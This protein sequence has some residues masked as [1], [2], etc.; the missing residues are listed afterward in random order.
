MAQLI[1]VNQC[2][3]RYQLDLRAYANRFTWLKKRR[4][5]EWKEKWGNTSTIKDQSDRDDKDNKSIKAQ[6]ENWFFE[7]QVGWATRT[8]F[9]VSQ[10]PKHLQ[11][12]HWVRRILTRINDVSFFMY[13]PVLLTKSGSIQLDSLIIGNDLICCVHPLIG[14]P[15]HVFQ[16]VSQRTWC[17]ITNG[18]ATKQLINPLI[19]L[20]RSKAVVSAFLR[21]HGLN[22][23][24]IKTAVYAPD[25]YIE[26]V[27]S[28]YE[29]DFVDR[30]NERKWFEWL[31]QHALLL[32][33]E[34]LDAAEMIL[35]HSETIAESRVD[36]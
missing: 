6:F 29:T 4:M 16:S 17:E 21:N 20:R 23:M 19:S 26:Q 33:R 36:D 27:M 28:S 5:E 13:Q 18:G 22:E 7:K 30:R 34:Q 11:E 8:A 1:K 2:V 15:G 24:V 32:K 35:Q 9:E 3:S 12:E 10:S 25:G 31:D 14:E